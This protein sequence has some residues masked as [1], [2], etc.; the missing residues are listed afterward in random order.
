MTPSSKLIETMRVPV[1]DVATGDIHEYNINHRLLLFL[2]R[3]TQHLQNPNILLYLSVHIAFYPI[4]YISLY[5]CI[6][7]GQKVSSELHK[8]Y[9]KIC[10]TFITYQ[11]YKNCLK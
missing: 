8:M 7:S 6:Q 11:I 5:W 1:V 2:M 3:N 4:K 10:F 9:T